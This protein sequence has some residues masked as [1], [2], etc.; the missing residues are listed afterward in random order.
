MNIKD[1]RPVTRHVPG[2][3][4]LKKDGKSGNRIVGKLQEINGKHCGEKW[5]KLENF[6]EK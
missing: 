2:G 5:R 3:Q 4:A 1:K 6:S